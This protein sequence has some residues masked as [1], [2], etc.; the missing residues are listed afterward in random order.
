MVPWHW[1]G[2][3]EW[4]LILISSV[5]N[6][7]V[8]TAQWTLRLVSVRDLYIFRAFLWRVLTFYNTILYE[9]NCD[10]GIMESVFLVTLHPITSEF[11]TL[12]IAFSYKSAYCVYR[13]GGG[14][15]PLFKFWTSLSSFKKL[16]N[17]MP[18]EDAKT[19]KFFHFQ[20]SVITAWRTSEFMR[21]EWQ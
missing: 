15:F 13:G 17:C 7:W 16:I 4:R 10:Y 5:V 21:R 14:L 2:K 6:D 8:C 20:N 9:V 1:Q 18:L 19:P 3:T 12:L 11:T